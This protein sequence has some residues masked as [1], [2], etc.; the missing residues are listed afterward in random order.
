MAA[1]RS[2]CGHYIFC[3]VVSIYLSFFISSPNL[4]GQRL[5]VYHTSTHGANLK[6]MSEMCCTRLAE[7]T[8][9]KSAAK[10][11]HLRTIAQL[12]R[13]LPS[14][15]RHVSTIEKNLLNSNVSPTRPRNTV[16]F[17]PLAAEIGSGI[18]G[19]VENFN[20]FRAL[21]A[22]LRGTLVVGVCQTL[23]R[24]TESAT[25]IRQGG[26]HVGHTHIV[27]VLLLC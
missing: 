11:R 25:Y 16:N 1:L 17:V 18:W 6:C 22:L 23:Q 19:T 15:L 13:A 27:C 9:R 7:N 20:G 21:A 2:R 4:S 5:D 8:G 14:Q 24:R 26:H 12:G 3:P 10:N